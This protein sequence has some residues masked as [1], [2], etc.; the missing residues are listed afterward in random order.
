MGRRSKKRPYGAEHVPLNM[1]RLRSVAREEAGPGGTYQV[2]EVKAREKPYTCPGC[3]GVIQIGTW[4][5][6]AWPTDAILASGV[7]A[8]RHWHSGCWKARF[9]RRLAW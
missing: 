7:N 2:Q 5:I 8:R 9:G 4:H 6:V 3:G 1:E